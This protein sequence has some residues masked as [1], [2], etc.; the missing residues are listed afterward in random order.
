MPTTSATGRP[1][2]AGFTLIE[3]LVVLA[4]TAA[5]AALVF[6]SFERAMDAAALS[7]ATS[8]LEADLRWA[9]AQ[10][11]AGGAQQTL[12]VAADGQ[13][14]AWSGGG[15]RRLP[16]PVR[17]TQA[18]AAPIAFFRDGSAVGGALALSAGGRSAAVLV[19]S[20]GV[21]YAPEAPR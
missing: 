15:E 19:T 20:A 7:R 17:I 14:W 12:G 13:T 6:P 21:V 18:S 4:I 1:L 9:R 10:A 2:Q 11:L 8:W 3:S 16:D 5:I